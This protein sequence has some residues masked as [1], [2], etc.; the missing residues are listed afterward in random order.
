MYPPDHISSSQIN[1]YLMC[2]LS[3]RFRYIDKIETGTK[4]SSLAMGT[5]FHTAAEALHKD[6]MNGGVRE[7]G[8]YRDILGD[9]LKTEFGNFEVKTKDGEDRDTL[10][11]EGGR[12][13]EVY[14]DYRTAQPGSILAAEQKLVVRPVNTRTAEVLDIPFFAYID[15]IEE[16]DGMP[17]VVDIKTTGRSYSQRDADDN[18]QLACYAL[19]MRTR[20]DQIP[21]LRID[22]VVRNKTPKMQRLETERTE[23]DLAR[24][25]TLARAVR[26]AT[27]AG[28]FHPNPGSWACSTCEF[29]DYCRRWGL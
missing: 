4:S 14:H 21:R 29:D 27:E 3:Y 12:L 18:L 5:S 2:P 10:T 22:A 16:E 8:V 25:W 26:D 17:V 13:V 9:S 15:L 20:Y 11:E 7:A 24:F 28:C 1:T 19:L 6:M 23:D